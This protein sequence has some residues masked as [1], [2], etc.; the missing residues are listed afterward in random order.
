IRSFPI[1][2]A[3]GKVVRFAG[4]ERDITERKLAEESVGSLLEITRHLNATLDVDVLLEALVRETLRLLAAE[5]GF[6]GL[7]TPEGMTGRRSG[8]GAGV[9]PFSHTWP[10]GRGLPG[11]VAVHKRLYVTND[12]SH[13]PVLLRPTRRRFG[14][15]RAMCAPFLD[16]CG[17]AVGF[18]QINNPRGASPFDQQHEEKL[19]AVVSAASV[20]VQH[21]VAYHKL[22]ET[23]ARLL[24][25][26]EKYRGIFENAVTGVGRT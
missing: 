17:E 26:E 21:A 6:A 13:D 5:G 9:E 10:R 24:L 19:L 12:A 4:V 16:A 20:A 14:V 3:S 15:R 25:T 8:A 7:M 22:R 1:R 18:V 2:D 11:W 23:A